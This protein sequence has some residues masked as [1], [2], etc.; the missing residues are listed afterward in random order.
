MLLIFEI[1]LVKIET[2]IISMFHFVSQ[3]KHNYN[4]M[5]PFNKSTVN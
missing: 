5:I 4:G 2:R 1:K 3:Y